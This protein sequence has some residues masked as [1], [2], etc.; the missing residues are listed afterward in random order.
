M[1]KKT[2]TISPMSLLCSETIWWEGLTNVD[3]EPFDKIMNLV[4]N[5][6]MKSF[7]A[8]HEHIYL[9]KKD[10]LD[11]YNSLNLGEN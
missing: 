5:I 3:I 9:K 6:A 1:I 2:A 4:A 11:I 7:Q 8:F 10:L